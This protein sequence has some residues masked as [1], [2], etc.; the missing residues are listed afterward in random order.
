MDTNMLIIIAV[1]VIVVLGVVFFIAKS[2][3]K[4]EPAKEDTKEQKQS[5]EAKSARDEEKAKLIEEAKQARMQEARNTRLQEEE[6]PEEKVVTKEEVAPQISLTSTRAKRDV[7]AHEKIVKEDFEIFS[8]MRILVAEDNMINQKV[9]K[10]L[11]AASGIELV[12]ADD[13]QIA[14]D[15]LEKD[16]DFVMVLMDAHMPNVDGFEATRQIR[17]NANYNNIVVTA[18]SGD[19]AADDIRNMINAGMQ[20]QLEK[21]LRMDAL[22]DI[23][24][25]YAD[26]INEKKEEAPKEEVKATAPQQTTSKGLD[27]EKG[28]TTCGGDKD[29]YIELLN[30]FAA[31][32]EESKVKLDGYLNA[33]DLTGADKLMHEIVGVSGNIGATSLHAHVTTI[34]ETIKAGDTQKCLTLTAKYEELLM[35]VLEEIV[36]Y[37]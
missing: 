5:A 28:L 23:L 8:G 19:T 6:I 26:T 29:F 2:K 36:D 17:A 35:Q 27:T 20:E 1:A 24:Y 31:S 37:Q 33:G 18:L 4:D 3:K 10:G 14:L 11:L 16:S 12:M 21:P 13:G 7:P 25:R 22:Y 15:T 34:R 9:I 30:E 32:Y